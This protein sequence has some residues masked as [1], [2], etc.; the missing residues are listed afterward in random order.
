MFDLIRVSPDND[1]AIALQEHLDRTRDT[2]DVT[3]LFDS[4]GHTALTFAASI[5]KLSACEVLINFVKD[6]SLARDDKVS[7]S[8]SQYTDL[9]GD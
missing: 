6:L 8:S 1:T 4:E 7:S 3:A 5:S 9:N 2:L